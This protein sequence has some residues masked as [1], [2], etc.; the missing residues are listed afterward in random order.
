[1]LIVILMSVGLAAGAWSA[2]R[3]QRGAT[4]AGSLRWG[5]RQR[6]SRRDLWTSP[7]LV[8]IGAAV[9]AW[10]AVGP[11]VP[12]A[13]SGR[14]AD[15]NPAA[16]TPG[17]APVL[18][19]TGER[20]TSYDIDLVARVDG[21]M[22]VRERLDYDFGAHQR[23]GVTRTVDIRFPYDDSF[24]RLYPVTHVTVSS[25]SGA[26]TT[27]KVSSNRD[28]VTLRIGDP[29]TTV[30]GVQTYVV[31]YD[32]AE[33]V[34]TFPDRQDVSWHAI[35][36]AWTVP[37]DQVRVRV[38]GPEAVAGTTCCRSADGSTATC[39]STAGLVAT[40]TT[41]SLTPG[42]GMT[43]TASFPVGTFPHAAP[44]LARI[45]TVAWGYALTAGTELGSVSL[46]TVL[47]GVL[48]WRLRGPGRRRDGPETT[49]GALPE[50]I[51]AAPPDGL[52]PAEVAFLVRERSD[53]G[54]VVATL[55]DLA[56][57]GHVFLDPLDAWRRPIRMPDGLQRDPGTGMTTA[58][59]PSDWGLRPSGVTPDAL[60]PYEEDLLA[61]IFA[62]GGPVTVTGLRRTFSPHL[63][64]Q[65]DLLS[66]HVLGHGW[67]RHDPVRR[68]RR[69]RRRSLLLLVFGFVLTVLL[70]VWGYGLLGIP[71]MVT[72]VAA[73]VTTRWVPV[74]TP[75]GSRLHREVLAYRRYLEQAGAGRVELE[76][77]QDVF[78]RHLP[79]AM[80]FSLTNRWTQAFDHGALGLSLDGFSRLASVALS[81]P[82]PVYSG[83][84][85]RSSGRSSMDGAS[86]TSGF[87][88]DASSGGG[89]T[90]DGGGGGSW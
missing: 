24:E 19:D 75:L 20:I 32:V 57:R 90:F 37:I 54:D 8:L 39:T 44:V 16:F 43:V 18:E 76:Q 84:W 40:Y 50:P 77:G 13:A 41:S 69:W 47:L 64:R 72:A 61:A 68:R 80:V 71:V 33:V 51:R 65:Q 73:L 15:Q 82:I 31:D 58:Q 2:W 46:L 6:A 30:T 52:R 11:A 85:V 79:Y 89:A 38:S 35:G 34:D 36:Q 17:P 3:R 67:F 59:F 28:I 87:V 4:L 1:M 10:L 12:A 25:A 56:V 27:L 22:H 88:G 45:R 63:R 81:A 62:G 21:S 53:V 66:A 23:H 70:S 48:W 26:S 49:S 60:A 78:G 29:A 55:V 9:T 74:R 7:E 83:P 5:D 42:E 14:A 86:D